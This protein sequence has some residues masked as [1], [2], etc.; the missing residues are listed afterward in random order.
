MSIK[1]MNLTGLEEDSDFWQVDNEDVNDHP[2]PPQI[3]D[4]TKSRS[5]LLTE[6]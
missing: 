5:L 4:L 2:A 3:R 6:V 1:A